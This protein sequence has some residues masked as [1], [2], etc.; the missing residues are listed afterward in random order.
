MKLQ[1]GSA[2]GHGQRVLLCVYL[3]ILAPTWALRHKVTSKNSSKFDTSAQKCENCGIGVFPPYS[4][5]DFNCLAGRSKFRPPQR[6]CS[7]ALRTIVGRYL[8]STTTATGE[9]HSNNTKPNRRDIVNAAHPQPLP[10]HPPRSRPAPIRYNYTK[11]NSC[12]VRSTTLVPSQNRVRNTFV[13]VNGPSFSKMTMDDELR[14]AE[15]CEEER[16]DVLRV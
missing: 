3:L 1:R 4:R 10:L 9:V 14:L 11:K 13:F 15:P 2:R 16:A 6:G 7:R 5:L 12:A 8:N